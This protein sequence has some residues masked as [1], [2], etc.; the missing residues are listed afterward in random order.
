MQ[1]LVVMKK[2]TGTCIP[3]VLEGRSRQYATLCKEERSYTALAKEERRHTAFCTVS[4]GTCRTTPY[5]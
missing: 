4:M 1:Y 5:T 3:G 2:E